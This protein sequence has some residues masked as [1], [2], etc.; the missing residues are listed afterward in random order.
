[1]EQCPKGDPQGLVVAQKE[2][3][4]KYFAQ[5]WKCSGGV[6]LI[7]AEG[8]SIPWKR[9]RELLEV[10]KVTSTE[11]LSYCFKYPSI[12]YFSL[13]EVPTKRR[14]R[15][16]LGHVPSPK[17][18]L[19]HHPRH[20]ANHPHTKILYIQLVSLL[21]RAGNP[22]RNAPGN[23]TGTEHCRAHGSWLSVSFDL[24]WMVRSSVCVMCEMR[25]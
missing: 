7:P 13:A 4:R 16:G 21:W 9:V 12:K 14:R 5:P 24:T 25:F 10:W 2:L 6:R 19:P 18:G 23:S 3:P 20:R 11:L 22:A 15:G 17:L 8:R 1:M